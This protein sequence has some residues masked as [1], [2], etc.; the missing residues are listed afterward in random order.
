MTVEG[1]V[2][3]TKWHYRYWKDREFIIG[4]FY[5]GQLVKRNIV[6]FHSY[7]TKEK[8]YCYLTD[9][10]AAIPKKVAQ[11]LIEVLGDMNT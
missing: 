1:Y 4:W 3:N 6:S 7:A 5:K 10:G 8:P 2:P 9:D 11:H